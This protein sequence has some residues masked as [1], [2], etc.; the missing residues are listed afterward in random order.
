VLETVLQERGF[1]GFDDS[2]QIQ[3]RGV[4]D[5]VARAAATRPAMRI[6]TI[7]TTLE[8]FA[9]PSE[10]AALL[11]SHPA[12]QILEGGHDNVPQESATQKTETAA[13]CA[14]SE[15]QKVGVMVSPCGC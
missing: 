6:H 12:E 8:V 3:R 2:G 1:L 5:R 9:H 15:H 10:A 13:S 11:V 4:Q 7:A 14:W